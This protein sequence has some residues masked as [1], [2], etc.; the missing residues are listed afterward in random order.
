MRLLMTMM[1]VA[2]ATTSAAGSW[3]GSTSKASAEIRLAE[4]SVPTFA[5]EADAEAFLS[6]ALPSATAAN[7]KY[8][9]PGTNYDRRWLIKTLT[10][11]RADRGGII[12]SLDE[13][14]EDYRGG[15]IVSQGMH[16]ARFAIGDV[17]IS[18]ETTDD[19]SD[20]GERAL[21]LLFQCAV[22]AVWDGKPSVS[23]RTN[24]Y[25]QDANQRERILSAFR[26]L[27]KEASR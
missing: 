14:F 9:T 22:H 7:P 26:A 24:I 25:I 21:G 27:K 16:Q 1:A 8:R 19:V 17:K 13:E 3:T 6:V 20:K 4:N 15:A 11:S 18:N 23:T 5:S 2:L 12:V 10:F